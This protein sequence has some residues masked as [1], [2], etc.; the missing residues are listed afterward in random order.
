M[1]TD[2]GHILAVIMAALRVTHPEVDIEQEVSAY[3]IANEM[4]NMAESL[5]KIIDAEDWL[6]IVEADD[7]TMV[8]WLL[9]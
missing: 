2:I 6:P 7:K 8:G 3:Y 5:D 9:L 4:A 1:L